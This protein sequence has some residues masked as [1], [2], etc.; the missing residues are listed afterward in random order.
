MADI[1]LPVFT[2]R[3]NWAGGVTERLSFLTDVLRSKTGSEQRRRLRNTPRRTIEADFLLTGSERTYFDLFTNKLG[4][5]EMMVPLFWDI[6][7]LSSRLVAGSA[8]RIDF[9]TSYREFQVGGLG[10]LMDKDALTFEVVEIAAIDGTGI[11]LA[12]P[13]DR[14]WDRGATLLPLRRCL[15]E[16]MGSPSHVTAAVALVTV[17]FL[18]TAPNPWTP[19]TDP[20]TVYSGLP[21]FAD[22]PNWADSLDVG[23][24]RETTRLDNQTGRIY[25]IDPLERSFISQAHRWFCPGRQKLGLLRDLL[26]RRAGRLGSFWLPTFKADLRLVSNASS[27]ATQITVEK[28]GLRLA[29]IPSAGREYIAIRHASG[30]IYRKITSTLP[31]LTEG[32]ERVNLDASLGLALSPGQVRKISFMDTARFDQDEFEITHHNGIDGL[33]ECQTTF[34]TFRNA[35]TAPTPIS[36]PIPTENKNNSACGHNPGICYYLPPNPWTIRIR[37]E[38]HPLR[39]P[40]AYPT[41]QSWYPQDVVAGMMPNGRTVNKGDN[42]PMVAGG[43]VI[44]SPDG[45]GPDGRALMDFNNP[46]GTPGG[47][48]SFFHWLD[49][50]GDGGP[51]G[52]EWFF[53]FPISPTDRTLSWRHQFGTGEI[54]GG[55]QQAT[56]R[57]YDTFGN[58]IN[59]VMGS[60]GNLWPY[61]YSINY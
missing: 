51:T 61:N 13:V 1:D 3:P 2:F 60:Y 38:F 46:D 17:R 7:T 30:T 39:K 32:T 55:S 50:N 28:T 15:L 34:Q 22:E 40:R 4:G 9:D 59:E 47:P 6:V 11:D 21:V 45:M 35:R 5:G 53:F 58:L 18:L 12:T 52:Y 33:H 19:A 23:L 49:P 10:L 16:D 57:A 37:L 26:Y 42:I 20:A 31:G 24:N 48:V 43:T 54:P 14:T 29:N 25:Q 8:E 41:I 27:S 44:P 36:L 56:I